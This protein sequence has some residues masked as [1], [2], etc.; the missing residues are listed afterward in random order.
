[1]SVLIGLGE[2][3]VVVMGLVGVVMGLDGCC[4]G[5]WWVL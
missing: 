1:M 4:D 5:S 3:F 2:C